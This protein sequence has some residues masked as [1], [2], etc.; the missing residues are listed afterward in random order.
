MVLMKMQQIL[1]PLRRAVEDFSM[2][3]DGDRIAVGLSGGKDSTALL[4]AL[5]A[6]RRFSPASFDLCAV[7]VDTGAGMDL[8]PLEKFCADLD[9][10]YVIEKT[11]IYE[12]VFNIRKEKNPCSLCAKMRRGALSSVLN[13]EGFNKLALGHHADDV[14]ETLIMSMIYEGRLNTFKPVSHMS[15][16]DVTV[17]RPFVYANE[18]DIASLVADEGMPVVKNPCPA[19]SDSRRSYVKDLLRGLDRDSGYIASGNIKRAIFHPE[20]NSLWEERDDAKK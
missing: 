4:A 13:R 14:A 5:S 15:R 2:I 3:A 18:K 16:T 17:I 10:R 6:F 20:R 11:D 1:S 9:V 8:K 7:T 12:I 19:D